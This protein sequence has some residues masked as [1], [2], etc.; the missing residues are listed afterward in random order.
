[1]IRLLM[2]IGLFVVAAPTSAEDFYHTTG[3]PLEMPRKKPSVVGNPA[4]DQVE[5]GIW[6]PQE[7]RPVR[8]LMFNPFGPAERSGPPEKHWHEACRL[9]RFALVTANY[10]GVNRKEFAATF[11]AALQEFAR[12]SGRTELKHAPFVVAGMSRGGGYSRAFALE[13]P[14]RALAVA[15]VCLEAPPDEPTLRSIPFLTVFGEKDGGQM[16]KIMTAHPLRRG[17]GALWGV[18]VQWGRGHEF[19]K[20]NNIVIPFFDAV[21]RRRLPPESAESSKLL[22]YPAEEVWLGDANSWSEKRRIGRIQRASDFRGD[23][24][25]QAWLPDERTARAWQAFVSADKE[26][27]I[28]EPPGLGDGQP[29]LAHEPHTPVKVRVAAKSTTATKVALY[30]GERLIAEEDGPEAEFAPSFEPGIH[31][32]YAVVRT[33]DGAE[34]FS[35]PHTLI[36]REQGKP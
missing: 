25:T 11:S 18:A 31:P 1:M 29:F 2:L 16:Q 26:V 6:I 15:P 4:L 36:V 30:D 7:A 24:A 20:A 14:E 32:L 9:W 28:L 27:K 35:F 3:I 21:I 13:F 22:K 19:A 34:R 5:Y 12:Q 10:D 33:V 23:P 17:E 8:G